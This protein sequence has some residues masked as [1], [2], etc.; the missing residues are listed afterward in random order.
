MRRDILLFAALLSLVLCLRSPAVAGFPGNRV[1]PGSTGYDEVTPAPPGLDSR[2]S[3]PAVSHRSSLPPYQAGWPRALEGY[4]WNAVSFVDVD[5]E[6]T[7]EV[8]ASS[9]V[10]GTVHLKNTDGTNYPNWPVY[11]GDYNYGAPVAG[12]V[13]GD[14]DM[15]VFQGA[16]GVAGN[17]ILFGWGHEGSD[18][19]GWPVNFP[20]GYQVHSSPAL[21]DLD[22]DGDL[23]IVFSLFRGDRT[24]VF[25]HDGTL[26]SGWPRSSPSDVRDTP[27][28]GDLDGDGDLEI[29]C[30][31]AYDIYA[32]HHDG[33]GISGFP[34]SVGSYY[35]D[36][37][38]MGDLDGDGQQ[39]IIVNTVGSN[40]NVR[41]YDS[42]GS[43]V[44]G[45]PRST[46]SSV[47]AEP[48]IGDLDNDRDLE[49]VIGGTGMG[50]DYHVWA[51]HHDGS[52][53]D[54][55]PAVTEMGEWCQSSAAIGDIDDDGDIEV[56]IGSDNHK[57][58][59]FHHDA[60]P[61][62]G[63]PITGPT[64]QVSAPVSIGDIDGDGDIEIGVGSLDRNIHIWD[65]EGM[66]DPSNVEW[67]TYHHDHWFTG[68]YHPVPPVNLTGEAIEG[69]VHLAWTSNLEPDVTGYNLYRSATSGYPYTR[70]NN[71]LVGD[72]TYVDE[73][74]VGGET[75][76]YVVT[77]VI[78]ARSES[79]YSGEIE[80]TVSGVEPYDLVLYPTGSI[81]VPRG[82]ILEFDTIVRNNTAFDVEGDLWLSVMMPDSME[83][84]IPERFL[85]FPNPLSGGISAFDSVYVSH[86]LSVPL[87]VGIGDYRMI[88]RIGRHPGTVL[89]E[90]SFG[91]QVVE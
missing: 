86:E 62:D 74:V 49:V 75:Y 61:V 70:V 52:A 48:C 66:L 38:A 19:S 81:V 46:G 85:T 40:D 16:N 41:V 26:F 79:R 4:I 30:A 88:G 84:L 20:D 23:E 87:R 37:I 13:D 3:E 1:H 56:I 28:V 89:D 55:W 34:V 18:L 12:D 90:E 78:R 14:G 77:A 21:S 58:Y 47:Y 33:T 59:A 32:W 35:T 50:I 11:F 76:Y 57:V 6:A 15:E 80:V 25:H 51:W 73:D 69:T 60:S 54:G 39:E 17:A 45:W 7:I 36:G 27:A 72:T 44:A 5:G 2:V 42:G 64:D 91:F 43:M 10:S 29:V 24:F 68:W 53:V 22:G 82:D 83:V 8:L 9:S 63:W 71:I 31:A 65:L 67:E